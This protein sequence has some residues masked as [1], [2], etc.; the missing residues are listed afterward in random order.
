MN[1]HY[2]EG[3]AIKHYQQVGNH[4][5]IA[6][7]NP[8]HL[9]TSLLE[10]AIERIVLAKGHVNGG[11]IKEKDKC[12]RSAMS[13][14]DGLRIALNKD[15]GGDIAANL[16]RLYD[17]MNRKLLEANLRNDIAVLDE[18]QGLLSQLKDAWGSIGA[19]APTGG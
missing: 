8:H 19:S 15:A 9:V 4:A 13:I 11:A 5:A 3:A 10:G 16:D 2:H 6:T 7:E 17:Y 12:I 1:Y 14:I 18:V